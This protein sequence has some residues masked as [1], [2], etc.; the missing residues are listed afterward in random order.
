MD[1]SGVDEFAVLPEVVKMFATVLIAL[2]MDDDGIPAETETRLR[3]AGKF[4]ERA[5]QQGIPTYPG[6]TQ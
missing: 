3:I 6:R 4:I 5:A 2:T 1:S